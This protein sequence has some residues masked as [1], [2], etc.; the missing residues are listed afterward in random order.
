MDDYR[1]YLETYNLR[2]I[3]GSIMIYLFKYID[4]ESKFILKVTVNRRQ[5][6]P[7]ISRNLQNI[8]P[9]YHTERKRVEYDGSLL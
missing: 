5:C 1:L 8:T 4:G 2:L 3:Y 6:E 9:E 7:D